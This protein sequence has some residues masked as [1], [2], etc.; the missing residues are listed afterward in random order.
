MCEV[1]VLVTQSCP[2]LWSHMDC[3]PPGSS[4]N[5]ILQA[6]MLEWVA[7]SFLLQG[8]FLTQG[9]NPGL[10][11]CR[12]ILY[13]LNHRESPV[14]TQQPMFSCLGATAQVNAFSHLASTE[15]TVSS[16]KSPSGHDPPHPRTQTKLF[17][18]M[19]PQTQL[20]KLV[21]TPITYTS[22]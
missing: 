22:Y 19:V 1:K 21:L 3:S 9:W 20:C 17:T 7:I 18:S 13:H 6:R 10:L 4:V 8:I 15:Q 5:G 2:T 14:P 12:W 11:H 16:F